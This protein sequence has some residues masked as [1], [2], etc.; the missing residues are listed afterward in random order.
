MRAL[1]LLLLVALAFAFPAH[2]LADPADFATATPPGHWYTETN[3][4]PVP[5]LYGFGVFDYPT[6]KFWSE[7]Q[8]LGGVPV[9]GYPVSGEFGQDGFVDQA[10]QKAILQGHPETGH[11]AFLNV[12]DLLHDAGLDPQLQAMRQV[13]PPLSTSS[14]TGK[15][16]DQVVAR[17]QALLAGD[18]A[19]RGA[20]FADPDPLA[21][22]GLPMTGPTDMGNVV[23]VR[24]QRAVLQRWKVATPWAAAGQ[25]TIANGGDIAK[26][27][28]LAPLYASTAFAPNFAFVRLMNDN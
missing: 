13:P 18:P 17:H 1:F 2:A 24:C 21:H 11:V 9:L 16:W 8:L 19:L 28:G 26:E 7:F 27:F 14:D 4:D 15:T 3:G 22:Y 20:Y 25:V 5:A 23:V 6:I 12:F 10:F